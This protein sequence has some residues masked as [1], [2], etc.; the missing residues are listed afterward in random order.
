LDFVSLEVLA[1][2]VFGTEDEG[3]ALGAPDITPPICAQITTSHPV[4]DIL[5]AD[6]GLTLVPGDFVNLPALEDVLLPPFS[7]FPESPTF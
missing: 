3:G 6:L 1:D 2:G 7:E 5:C 4:A